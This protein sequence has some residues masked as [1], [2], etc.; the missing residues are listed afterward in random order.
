MSHTLISKTIGKYIPEITPITGIVY[1]AIL[2]LAAF[3]LN[4]VY[5]ENTS[6]EH[7]IEMAYKGE[8]M[9]FSPAKLSISLGDKVTFVMV[10]GAPHTVTFYKAKV[11]GNTSEEKS[12]LA[13]F[14]SYKKNDGYFHKPGETYTVHFIDVPKGKYHFYCLPH[15]GMGMKGMI[16][17]K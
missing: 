9:V 16:K 1:F 5:A 15:Q 3:S 17:V 7:T 10:S 2:L 13:E 4:I 11:P 8:K 6:K 14:L 12:R